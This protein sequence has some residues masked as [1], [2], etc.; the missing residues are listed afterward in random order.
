MECLVDAR[1]LDY[2]TK[3]DLRSQLKM[4][5]SFHRTSLQCGINCLKRVNHDK[6]EL[7][8]R[9]EASILENKGKFRLF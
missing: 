8:R 2:L 5:D 4:V 1:M 7:R 3:K 6:H 9:R